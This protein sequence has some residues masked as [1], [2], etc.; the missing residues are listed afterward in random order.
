MKTITVNVPE[1]TVNEIE[2]ASFEVSSR[3]GVIDRYLEKHM[4]DVDGSAI[5]SKPF[6]HFMSLLTEAEA[7]FE[8]AKQEIE[9]VYVPALVKEHSYEWNL[10]YK[11]KILTITIKCD[12]EIDWE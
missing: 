10:D 11:S 2:R 3:R 6:N 7:H 1:R 9:D 12:C 8:L 4:N 5:N